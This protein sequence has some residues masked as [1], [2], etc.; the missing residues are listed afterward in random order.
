[1]RNSSYCIGEMVYENG[2]LH[3]VAMLCFQEAGQETS[4]FIKGILAFI[5]VAFI[6][7]TLYVYKIIPQLRD[8]Q[9]SCRLFNISD[10]I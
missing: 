1:M 9:V 7:A 10:L 4:I 8:T 3:E 6:C 2:T 5:S